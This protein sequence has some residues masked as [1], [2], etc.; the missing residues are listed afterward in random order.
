MGHTK[1]ICHGRGVKTNQ[2]FIR[3][4]VGF[5]CSAMGEHKGNQEFSVQVGVLDDAVLL[6]GWLNRDE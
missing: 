5:V 3:K 4:T 2:K 6:V 1:H